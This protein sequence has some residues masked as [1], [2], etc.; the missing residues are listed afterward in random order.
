MLG[1][2]AT[3]AHE[4]GPFGVVVNSLSP[5]QVTGPRMARNFALEGERTGA[6]AVAAEEEFVSRAALHRMVTEDE[7][8]AAV[9]AMPGLCGADIDLSSR[10]IRHKGRRRGRAHE[11]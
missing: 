8:A 5:G 10:T 6:G 7:V 11:R 2:T 4:V 3:L 9:L 1:L